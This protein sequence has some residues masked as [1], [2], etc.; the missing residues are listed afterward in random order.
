MKTVIFLKNGQGRDGSG[1]RTP[2]AHAGSRKVKEG[3]RGPG[4][5]GGI[6]EDPGGK[7][8]KGK[9]VAAYWREREINMRRMAGQEENVSWKS[10]E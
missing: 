7:N 8:E 2:G 6:A 1:I 4:H 10:A 9:G 3:G 5:A